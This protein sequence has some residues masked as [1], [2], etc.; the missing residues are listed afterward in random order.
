L[1]AAVD[2]AQLPAVIDTAGALTR[3][4]QVSAPSTLVVV[5]ASGAVTERATDPTAQDITAAV[6]KAGG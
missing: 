2:G 4:F 5:D 1:L 3:R 6:K